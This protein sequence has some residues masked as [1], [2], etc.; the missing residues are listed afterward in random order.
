MDLLDRLR[1]EH[2][3]V[4]AGLGGGLATGE[5][6]AAGVCSPAGRA[7]RAPASSSPTSN[8]AAS[9]RPPSSPTGSGCTTG[10]RSRP[11]CGPTRT[12][13][14]AGGW[15]RR[16]ALGRPTADQLD[17]RLAAALDADG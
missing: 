8:P 4:Q 16:H 12:R 5:V 2:P 14:G 10:E 1:L 11:R 7:P 6:S 15:Y 13:T 9:S 17:S 3:V